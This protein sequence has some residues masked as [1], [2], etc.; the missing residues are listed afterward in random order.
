MIIDMDMIWSSS[1]F[2]FP[3]WDMLGCIDPLNQPLP[4][5]VISSIGPCHVQ[6]TVLLLLD[7]SSLP[8]P[9]SSR[10]HLH[11]SSLPYPDLFPTLPDSRNKS[12]KLYSKKKKN[13]HHDLSSETSCSLK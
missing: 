7:D 4:A 6:S 5:L 9:L 12:K 13:H 10:L 1:V 11:M 2:H 3:S 8:F